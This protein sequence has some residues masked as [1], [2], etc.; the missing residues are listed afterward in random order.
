[1][2]LVEVVSLGFH[3]GGVPGMFLMTVVPDA[4]PQVTHSLHILLDDRPWLDDRAY[5]LLEVPVQ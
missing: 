3:G 1:M 5:L 2:R 4:L